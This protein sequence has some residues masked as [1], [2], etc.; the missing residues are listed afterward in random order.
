MSMPAESRCPFCPAGV[1][2]PRRHHDDGVEFVC[3]DCGRRHTRK[4]GNLEPFA[5]Y[6]GDIAAA[7]RD[8]D[9]LKPLF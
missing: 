9:D 5:L 4:E 1:A 3:Q 6:P 8:D 2:V 7:M